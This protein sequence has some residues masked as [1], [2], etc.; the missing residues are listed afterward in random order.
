MSWIKEIDEHE[1]SGELAEV[2]AALQKMRGKVANILKIHSLN[3]RSLKNHVDLYMTLMFGDSGLGRGERESIAVVTS[4]ANECDYCVNHHEEALKRYQKDPE[5]LKLLREANG[6]AGL[7]ARAAAM[8]AHARKLTKTPAEVSAADI[9]ALRVAGFDDRDIL[10]ITLIVAYFNF[11]NR[12]ALGLG[13]AFSD[14][15]LTGYRA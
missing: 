6:F 5:T 11:V 14:K 12:V 2:Y 15:E 8:L 1:A 13:V 10:D 3:P 7:D 4:A 9:D